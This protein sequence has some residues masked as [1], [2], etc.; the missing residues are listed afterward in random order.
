MRLIHPKVLC[1]SCCVFWSYEV[2]TRMVLLPSH[3][4]TA[5]VCP[6]GMYFHDHQVLR[7]WWCEARLEAGLG[8]YISPSRDGGPHPRL[9]QNRISQASIV[10]HQGHVTITWSMQN[11]CMVPWQH[12]TGGNT[13]LCIYIMWLTFGQYGICVF[14]RCTPAQYL[15]N[16]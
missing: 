4:N 12:D 10:I 3:S 9:P 11:T 14:I 16:Q 13:W 15:P 2:L 8:P 6:L 7:S 5:L 1:H